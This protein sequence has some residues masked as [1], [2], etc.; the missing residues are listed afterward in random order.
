MYLIKSRE[1]MLGLII[2][3]LKN[4]NIGKTNI[5]IA[6]CEIEFVLNQRESKNYEEVYKEWSKSLDEE[7][8]IFE[9]LFNYIDQK[10]QNKVPKTNDSF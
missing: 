1:E 10:L 8:N 3:G 6:V 4:A 2:E 7:Q 5:L 9:K